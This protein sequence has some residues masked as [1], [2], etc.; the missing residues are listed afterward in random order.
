MSNIFISYRRE[1][2]A[3]HTG[4][5]FD[6][7]GEHFGKAHVFMDIA[8]IEPGVDFV[9]AIDHA[10]GSCDAFI[11]VIGKQWLNVTDAE[12]RRRIDN[13]EDFIHLELAAALRRNIRV[14]PVLVQGAVAPGSGSLPEDLKKLSRLQAHEI[15]DNRWDYDVGMLIESLE[16]VLKKDSPEPPGVKDDE[17]AAPPPKFP[18]WIIAILAAIV[19]G[20][21]VY[22]VRTIITP[23][24]RLPD[25]VGKPYDDAKV[26]L[27]RVGLEVLVEGRHPTRERLPGTVLEQA[28]N[29]GDKVKRGQRIRLILAVEPIIEMPKVSGKQIDEAQAIL[30][31]AGLTVIELKEVKT[32]ERPAGMVLS[33][34]PEPG[35]QIEP[36]RQILLEVAIQSIQPKPGLIEV[37]DVA[38]LSMERAKAVLLGK[39]LGLVSV[40]EE[41]TDRERPGVVLGT[42]PPRGA[43]VRA[44][45]RIILIVAAPVQRPSLTPKL[46]WVRKE[47]QEIR[48][49]R[50][51][52]YHISIKNWREFPAELFRPAPDL[53]P[54]GKNSNASRTWLTIYN[55]KDNKRIYG[56]CAF[57]SPDHL[58]EFTFSVQQ[59]K[60]PPPAVYVELTDRRENV[61]YRSNPVELQ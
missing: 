23:G 57:S 8:G 3:G 4:R 32:G 42:D 54:C 38:G 39:E 6:R 19:V 50:F 45:D 31:E 22:A 16:K 18:R 36:D 48:G 41:T 52:V 1:D 7:L 25:V 29:P 56:Y 40:Q 58:R 60:S 12:G 34:N 20:I 26:M 43:R 14:I 2:S 49:T 9:E 59:G 11:V 35:T 37:P 24:I 30:R 51:V 27:E 61:K 15:S 5:L 46:T 33:Q 21:G 13:P 28:P 53:P 17:A 44:R 47:A 55:A 10:V